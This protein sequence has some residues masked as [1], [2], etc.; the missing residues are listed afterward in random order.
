MRG[1]AIDRI[2]YTQDL[3]SRTGVISAPPPAYGVYKGAPLSLCASS[4][5]L[6]PLQAGDSLEKWDGKAGGGERLPGDFS[7]SGCT[8]SRGFKRLRK[9]EPASRCGCCRRRSSSGCSFAHSPVNQI[10]AS[11]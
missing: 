11:S 7:L 10:S 1:A 3:D 2:L 9:S 8:R 5:T 4:K 6:T